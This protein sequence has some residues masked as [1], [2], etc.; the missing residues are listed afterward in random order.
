ME[1]AANIDEEEAPA[2]LVYLPE[3]ITV[4]DERAL[5]AEV[6]RLPFHEVRMHGVIAKRTVIHFGWDY[7]YESWKLSPGLP[8]PAFL[9]PLRARCAEV[10]SLPVEALEQVLVA[11][12]PEGAGIGWHRDA[13]MFGPSVVGASL[14][15]PCR[16]RFQRTLGGARETYALTLEPRSIYLL[17]GAARAS[18]QHTIPRAL[19]LRYSVT[20]RTLTAKARAALAAGGE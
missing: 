3:A 8:I 7:G 13:P 10:A 20:F 4:E 18:W 1:P 16:M 15:A 14:G 19:G 2:G 5:V 17:S 6:E 9:E 12:Y 11:R